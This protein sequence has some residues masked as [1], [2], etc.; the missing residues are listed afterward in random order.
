MQRLKRFVEAVEDWVSGL[1]I[2][3]G[4][5]LIFYGI[6]ARGLFNHP[7][8]WIE[9]ISGYIVVWGILIGAVVALREN[10]HIRVDMVYMLLPERWKRPVDIFANIVGLIFAI[11]M[12]VYGIKGIF[13]DEYGVYTTGLVSIGQGI[14]LWKVYLILPIIGFLLIL[15]FILRITRLF[16]GLPETDH[17]DGGGILS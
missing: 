3:L 12:L 7:I 13:F 4:L 2:A 6:I 15:R 8:G 5:G 10:H 9:E 16:K 1:L 11:F 14:A 17:E